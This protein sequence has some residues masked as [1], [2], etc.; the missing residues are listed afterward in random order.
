ML[1][2]ISLVCLKY[3]WSVSHTTGLSHISLEC[4]ISLWTVSH[5]T[6]VSNIPGVSQISYNIYVNIHILC[7]RSKPLLLCDSILYNFSSSMLHGC[8]LLFIVESESRRVP[9][10]NLW[11]DDGIYILR[12]KDPNPP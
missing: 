1:S 12:K 6:G 7:S 10:T 5:I 8:W 4:Q 2:Q 11:F 3:H 9:M